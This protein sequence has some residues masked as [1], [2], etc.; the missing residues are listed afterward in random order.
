MSACATARARCITYVV[1]RRASNKMIANFLSDPPGARRRFVTSPMTSILTLARPMCPA[2]PRPACA[3]ADFTSGSAR[4]AI[5][6]HGPRGS[7]HC[8]ARVE[9][10]AHGLDNSC[11]TPTLPYAVA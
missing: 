1:A 4:A 11:G 10:A 9:R 8:V 7:Q 6:F 5:W 2:T 3:D